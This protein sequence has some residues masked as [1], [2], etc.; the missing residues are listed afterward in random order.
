MDATVCF[1]LLITVCLFFQG[2]PWLGQN[3][4]NRSRRGHPRPKSHGGTGRNGKVSSYIYGNIDYVFETSAN[5]GF[6]HVG[7]VWN[8][9][10][11][12]VLMVSCFLTPSRGGGY[13]TT[14]TSQSL[15]GALNR[16]N[17][18]M[19]GGG[20]FGRRY[21]GLNTLVPSHMFR[22]IVKLSAAC[23]LLT[24]ALWIRCCFYRPFDFS[25]SF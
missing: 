4:A 23:I 18:M 19:Q 9:S 22:C 14:G 17:Q 5:V 1:E 15:S 8:P 12:L 6:G 13:M 24:K 21:W 20:A 3:L 11:I 16:Q 2:G 25:S 10:A 7:P